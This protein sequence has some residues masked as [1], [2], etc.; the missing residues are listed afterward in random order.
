MSIEIQIFLMRNFILEIR[1]MRYF[2]ILEPNSS[3]LSNEL[4]IK[5]LKW[6]IVNKESS[7]WDRFKRQI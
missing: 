1:M 5:F 6:L 2:M 3:R 7:K 4:S